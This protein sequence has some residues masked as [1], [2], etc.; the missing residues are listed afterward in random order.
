MSD[1]DFVTDNHRVWFS[2]MRLETW[3]K[4]VTIYKLVAVED[5]LM[6][7]SGG[8]YH[9]WVGPRIQEAHDEWIAEN[10]ILGVDNA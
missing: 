3:F 10:I 4:F 6:M 1:P 2:E 8:V 7:V 5:R 9:A